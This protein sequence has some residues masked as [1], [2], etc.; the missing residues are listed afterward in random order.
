MGFDLKEWM[1]FGAVSGIIVAIIGIIATMFL[2]SL[3]G[4][5]GLGLG[6]ALTAIAV[7][8]VLITGIIQWIALGW[9]YEVLVKEYVKKYSVYWQVFSL[10]LIASAFLLLIGSNLG[11]STFFGAVIGGLITTWILLA[12]AKMFKIKVPVVKG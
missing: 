8:T 7:I 2:A 1:K 3:L 9:V 6:V 12:V 11:V 5:L 4:S 10:S